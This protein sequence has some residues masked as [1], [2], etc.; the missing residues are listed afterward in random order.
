G[1]ELDNLVPELAEDRHRRNAAGAVARVDRDT[2]LPWRTDLRAHVVDVV[3]QHGPLDDSA[4][5]LENE[6][7]L[8]DDLPDSTKIGAVNRAGADAD[9]EPVVRCGIV[10]GGDHHAAVHLPVAHGE[11]EERCGTHPDVGHLESRLEK[12]PQH[13]CMNARRMYPSVAAERDP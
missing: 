1:V 9:L 4:A 3:R 7:A 6:I 13:A 2:Q 11:V 10:A 5:R 8:L 12:T